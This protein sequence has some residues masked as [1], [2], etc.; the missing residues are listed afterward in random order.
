MSKNAMVCDL[1]INYISI[2]VSSGKMTEKYL[3][4]YGM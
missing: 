1:F 2:P 4:I 3:S